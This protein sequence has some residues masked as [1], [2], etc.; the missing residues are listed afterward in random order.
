MEYSVLYCWKWKVRPVFQLRDQFVL[1]KGV[2]GGWFLVINRCESV[3]APCLLTL[4]FPSLGGFIT[5]IDLSQY[6]AGTGTRFGNL[7]FSL[8]TVDY[9]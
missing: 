8:I 4:G 6:S 1:M 3:T 9:G 2:V 5:V 7:Q